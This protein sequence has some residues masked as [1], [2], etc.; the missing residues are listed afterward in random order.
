MKEMP[1]IVVSGLNYGFGTELVLDDLS[2]QLEKGSRCLLVGANGAGKSTLL[3][4]LAGKT[5][6]RGQVLVSGK[7]AFKDDTVG[8]TYLGSEWAHNPVVK[9]DVPVSRLLLSLGAKRHPERLSELLDILD[10]SFLFLKS[11][12]NPNWSMNTISDG[13]RRRVQ[14]VLGLLEPWEVLLLDEVTVDLDVLVR[15]DLVSLS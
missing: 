2:L 1:A 13:Q 12:V 11:Q 8:V 14:I 4:I 5:L 6:V 3:R 9:G 7:N 15:Q 10:V